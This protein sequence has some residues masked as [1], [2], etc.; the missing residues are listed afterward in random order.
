DPHHVSPHAEGVHTPA[1]HQGANHA[2]M[3]NPGDDAPAV[4][5]QHFRTAWEARD[6]HYRACLMALES[7]YAEGRARAALERDAARAAVLVEAWAWVQRHG[8]P[9]SG[10]ADVLGLSPGRVAQLRRYYAWLASD[11]GRGLR[12]TEGRFRAFWQQLAAPG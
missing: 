11:P 4:P 8:L 10:V 1:P 5:R 2:A 9:Q 3:V 12:L 7:A 6:Q